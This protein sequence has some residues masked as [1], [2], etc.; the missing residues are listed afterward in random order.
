MTASS[1][2]PACVLAA[3]AMLSGCMSVATRPQTQHSA[4]LD[5]S[6]A[7]LGTAD[8]ALFSPDALPPGWWR[9][10][11]DPALNGLVETAL[12]ENSD[13]RVAQANLARAAAML[14]EAQAGRR[15]ATTV[16]ASASAAARGGF[17]QDI[18]RD[19]S[20]ALGFGVSYT[21]DVGGRIRHGIDAAA[22]E[23]AAAEAARDQVRVLV[24]AAM[25]RAYLAVCASSRSIAAAQRVV[26]VQRDTLRVTESLAYAGRGTDFDVTRARAAVMESQA[27][28]PALTAQRQAALFEIA[29]LLGRTAADRPVTVACERPPQLGLPLP[30]GDGAQLLRRRPDVRQAERQVVAANALIGVA[31]ADLYPQI[32]LGASLGLA[33]PHAAPAF[34]GSIGP[35]IA[36][37]IPDRTVARARIAQADA[38][39]AAALARFDGTVLRAVMEVE[40]AL[41]TY[42]QE[43]DRAHSLEQ[44]RDDA[45]AAARQA[46]ALFTFGRIDFMDVLASEA[47]F[48]SAESRWAASQAQLDGAR[49]DVFLALGGGWELGPTHGRLQP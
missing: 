28:L 6:I 18:P 45:A 30:V 9:L 15:P 43:I 21:L 10:Y 40:T 29:A 8:G 33:G 16:S 14:Q 34:G 25:S 7:V 12:K 47:M 46:T 44:A 2:R 26:E 3:I 37:R 22:A 39:A 42:A 13:V 20:Y 23:Q 35:L 4:R 36:W 31:E 17:T 19:L 49:I 41:S 24:A 5:T 32:S 38:D 1:V 11:D 27:L 48:A